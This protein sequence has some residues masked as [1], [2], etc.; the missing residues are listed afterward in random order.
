MEGMGQDGIWQFKASWRST[1]GSLTIVFLILAF[2]SLLFAFVGGAKVG[3]LLA[4]LFFAGFAWLFG[5]PLFLGEWVI[6]VGPRG[7]SGHALNNRTVPWRDV[8]DLGVETVQRNTFVVLTLAPE[9]TESLQKTRRW[10]SGKKP[11]RRIPLNG[12]KPQQAEIAAQAAYETF[13][14]RAAPHAAAAV[15]A[16]EAE[17]RFEAEFADALEQHTPL[18]W[19]L[20]LV[21]ALNVGVWV[22]NVARG[23]SPMAPASPDL[24]RWGANSAWAVARD[25]E[26]WRLLTGTFLHGGAIHLGMNMLGLWGAGKLLNRLYGNGQFLLVYLASALAGSAASLHF[27][28]QTAV[29]VGASGAVFGVLGAVVVASRRHRERLPKALTRNILTSEGVFLAYALV[30]GFTRAGIDNAAHVG[31]LVAGAGL[32]WLLV[33]V[34]ASGE[35]TPVR[36]RAGL[37]AGLAALAV[38]GLVFAT[39]SPRINHRALFAGDAAVQEAMPRLKSAHEGLEQDARAAQAG[40]MTEQQLME[41]VEKVHLPALRAS[42]AELE[43]LPKAQ[44]D[45]RAEMLGDMQQVTAK[46]VEALELQL[47]AHRGEAG[48]EALARIEQIKREI[49]SMSQRMQQRAAAQAKPAK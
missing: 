49:Q 22:A 2:L 12:L 4:F 34:V 10:L 17:A 44:G 19:A 33:P 42:R 18:T 11:E 38:M 27:G 14:E 28:A 20:Y 8:R 16:R 45:P 13:K 1:I 31:G 7:I 25:H 15:Q 30:N 43:R 32:A 35:G 41:R 37:A 46:T 26:Y 48:P 24:F 47:R 5:K 6:R 9:A 36:G 3:P 23:M 21:V 29:S 40:R 39:P